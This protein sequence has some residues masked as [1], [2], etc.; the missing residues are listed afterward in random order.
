MIGPRAHIFGQRKQ[1]TYD[2][3]RNIKDRAYGKWKYKVY[4]STY[5]ESVNE[6]KRHWNAEVVV[7]IKSL[8]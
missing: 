2:F 6:H 3:I 8:S 7:Y 5:L 4:K 1:T